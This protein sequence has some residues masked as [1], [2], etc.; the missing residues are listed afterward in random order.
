MNNR[1]MY[2]STGGV[3]TDD[4][5]SRNPIMYVHIL[6]QKVV[7]ALRN[8]PDYDITFDILRYYCRT[9][10]VAKM[11]STRQCVVNYLFIVNI[12]F[13]KDGHTNINRCNMLFRFKRINI[14]RFIILKFFIERKF[15][16]LSQGVL[17]H[18][19]I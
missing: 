8:M 13:I 2:F 9:I 12:E 15:I 19:L 4:T 18:D 7:F 1:F 6:Y 3:A 11:I 17:I 14:L 10:K 5:I 16:N